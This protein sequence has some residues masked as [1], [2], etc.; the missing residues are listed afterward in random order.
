MLLVFVWT[1]S[2]LGGQASL[3]VIG[4]DLE[5]DAV[6]TR[7]EYANLSSNIWFSTEKTQ[8]IYGSAEV[9]YEAIPADAL[10]A[11]AMINPSNTQNKGM[12][13]WSNLKVPMIEKL[14]NQTSD[15]LGWY[16]VDV[17][18]TSLEHSSLIGLPVSA[19]DP[20]G[21]TSFNIETS[22]WTLDC[23]DLADGFIYDS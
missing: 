18:N 19:I 6:S 14:P 8:V 10:F 17:N 9:I 4:T 21:N 12:D 16:V 1:L 13:P 23:F 2:P 20:S 11:A 22:Y 15:E 3:R 7:I 5:T